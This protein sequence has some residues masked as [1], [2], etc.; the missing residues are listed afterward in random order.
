MTENFQ[1][2]HFQTIS[3]VLSLQAS[4]GSA[5]GTPALRW[6]EVKVKDGGRFR[7]LLSRIKFSNILMDVLA[8]S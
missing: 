8:E 3:T 5:S 7:H 2:T 1:K 4:T 6:H